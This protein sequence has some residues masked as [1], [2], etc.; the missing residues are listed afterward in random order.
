MNERTI[1]TVYVVIDDVLKLGQHQS[2][3]LSQ[4]SD[5][6]V[7]TVAVTAALY[8]R[9]HQERTLYVLERM[10][11]LSGHLSISR[12][13]RRLHG[14][15]DW[16]EMVLMVLSEVWTHQSVY[17]IDSMPLPVCRRARAGRCRKVRG[18]VYYG[19]CA[20][21]DERFFGWR[22]H[23]ICT[24]DGLPVSFSVL[25]ASY[26]DLTPVH[27]LTYGLPCGALVVA[28]KGYNSGKDE[29]SLLAHT[30]VRLV[31]KR[32]DNM[33]PNCPADEALIALH[34]K[35]IE[36]VNSQLENMGIQDLHARTNE[37][38][39]LKLHASLLALLCANRN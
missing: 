30:G 31:V 2:H 1:I 34:R 35:R 15:R 11:Y 17:I 5:A 4:I 24:S 9:N 18:K 29:S 39:L 8:F 6:E 36:T 16:L 38:F 13:N 37:G 19:Y 7:L 22:L 27:E 3:V 12:F 20:A 28:D 21:K 14:L 25:P 26:H 10:G 32:K 33:L 23:L